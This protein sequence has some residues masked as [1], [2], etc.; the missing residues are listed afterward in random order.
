MINLFEL[1][2]VCHPFF[3]FIKAAFCAKGFTSFVLHK[4]K[5]SF[6]PNSKTDGFKYFQ[7]KLQTAL[8]A[9]SEPVRFTPLINLLDIICSDNLELT[10]TLL[11]IHFSNQASLNN[12]CIFNAHI[13]TFEECLYTCVFQAKIF[14]T[15]ALSN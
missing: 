8:Q 10:K 11:N 3:I 9:I 12:S 13:G 14:G 2:Q 1:L 7:A 5:A 4:T 6:H 15:A